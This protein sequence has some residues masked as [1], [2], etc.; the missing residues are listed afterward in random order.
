M[1]S[2][3]TYAEPLSSWLESW[4]KVIL[5]FGQY[6]VQICTLSELQS[7]DLGNGTSTDT[8]TPVYSCSSEK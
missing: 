5:L 1:E 8:E 7:G 2:S 4:E 6:F 3:K